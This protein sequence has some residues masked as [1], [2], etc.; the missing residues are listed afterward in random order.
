[1]ADM[2]ISEPAE[3]GLNGTQLAK[4]DR[5]L[6]KY[7]DD[8]SLAGSCVLIARRGQIA[9]LGVTGSSDLA[10][11]APMRDDT[12]FRIYSMTKP[13]TCLVAMQLFEEGR[14]QLDDRLDR[15]I[16]RFA[17]TGVYSGGALGNF[18]T[19]PPARPTGFRIA[20]P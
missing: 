12:I 3:V 14:L 18:Q 1:M 15:Y 11:G 8:G 6:E 20:P 17:Q 10:R 7:V 2:P 9:H 19:T 4:I 5:H 16:P 13:I